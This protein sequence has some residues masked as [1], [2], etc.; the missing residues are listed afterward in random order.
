MRQNPQV[1]VHHKVHQQVQSESASTSASQ[2]ASTSASESGKY[3][4]FQNAS[5]SASESRRVRLRPKVRQNP[6]VPSSVAKCFNKCK[7]ISEVLAHRKVLQPVRQNLQAHQLLKC[8]NQ[9]VRV[10]R[11]TSA[12]QSASTSASGVSKYLGIA[13]CFNQRK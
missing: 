11:I 8:I 13:K 3:I 1:Q 4:C 5:T 6:Q 10:L 9:C 7:R 12:S 2:S